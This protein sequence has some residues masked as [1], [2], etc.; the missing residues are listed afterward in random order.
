MKSA[1]QQ[2]LL[3]Y[4]FSAQRDLWN[5]DFPSNSGP[6][7]NAQEL[8]TFHVSLMRGT[9]K[10]IIIK[11]PYLLILLNILI[12]GCDTCQAALFPLP[13]WGSFGIQGATGNILRGIPR[14]HLSGQ[15]CQKSLLKSQWILQFWKSPKELNLGY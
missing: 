9:H 7:D 8:G 2:M 14:M 15:E 10:F 4:L 3:K 1:K 6:C 5:S 11:Y 12:Q 13:H